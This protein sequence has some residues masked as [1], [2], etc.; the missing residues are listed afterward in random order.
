MSNKEKVS[1]TFKAS[2]SPYNRDDVAG[3]DAETAKAYVDAGVADYTP[4][5]KR[6]RRVQA[7]AGAQADGLLPDAGGAA[8][9]LGDEAQA[10]LAAG[11][12]AAADAVGGEQVQAE[13][14]AG[15]AAE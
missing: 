10:D 6:A 13:A 12:E 15:A 5:P 11:D 8:A 3:F 4:V 2:A 1:V 9:D 7:S 14:E